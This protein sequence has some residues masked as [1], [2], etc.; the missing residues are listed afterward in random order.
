ME[1]YFQYYFKTMADRVLKQNPL[2]AE[3][4]YLFYSFLFSDM[5]RLIASTPQMIVS[6]YEKNVKRCHPVH[7]SLLSKSGES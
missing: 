6:N 3:K 5:S 1:V 7:L 4:V 2:I